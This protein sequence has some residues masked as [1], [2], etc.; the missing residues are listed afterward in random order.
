MP[1]AIPVALSTRVVVV[2][3]SATGI[4]FHGSR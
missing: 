1:A 3:R 2:P 4:C